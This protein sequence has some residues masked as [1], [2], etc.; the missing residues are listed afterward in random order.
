MSNQSRL[1]IYLIYLIYFELIRWSG[2][3]VIRWSGDPVIL[4]FVSPGNH[5][6]RQKFDW[7]QIHTFILSHL[8]RPFVLRAA[9]SSI[10]CY[11]FL[12]NFLLF[13]SLVLD[14][15]CVIHSDQPFKLLMASHMW[16][17]LFEPSSC[18]YRPYRSLYAAS[19][20]PLTQ[21]SYDVCKCLL[22]SFIFIFSF[23]HFFT[24]NCDNY[25]L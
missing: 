5:C 19:H 3:P 14:L 12:N 15:H 1:L 25:N 18:L 22:F 24:L 11:S 8:F 16:G 9:L 10:F 13:M 6:S 4:Y 7:L 17:E 20:R 2:D 23:V 21:I